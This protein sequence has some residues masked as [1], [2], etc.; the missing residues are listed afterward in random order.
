MLKGTLEKPTG[1]DPIQ[2]T[3]SVGLDSKLREIVDQLSQD[4]RLQHL[5]REQLAAQ[6]A[7]ALLH[8]IEGKHDP[9]N[10]ILETIY[11]LANEG[12]E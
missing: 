6:A 12:D 7:T 4:R 1:F 10:F 8:W 2:A 9:Q 11:S 3:V 5:N